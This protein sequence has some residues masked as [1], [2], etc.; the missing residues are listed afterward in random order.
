MGSIAEGLARGK[1]AGAVVVILGTK[2]GFLNDVGADLGYYREGFL[3]F[4]ETTL[5]FVIFIFHY[6]DALIT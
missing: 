3:P 1:T 6:C 2:N 5:E 4:I